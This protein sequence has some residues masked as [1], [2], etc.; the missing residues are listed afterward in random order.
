MLAYTQCRELYS[1]G[2]QLTDSELWNLRAS[3][4]L[5]SELYP[6]WG[7][8]WAENESMREDVEEEIDRRDNI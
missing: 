8:G 2:P 3:L 1:K 6:P 7:I 4:S 5:Y